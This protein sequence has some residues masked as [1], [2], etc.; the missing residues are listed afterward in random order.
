[1]TAHIFWWLVGAADDVAFLHPIGKG[2]HVAELV[3]DGDDHVGL[4]EVQVAAVHRHP[5]FVQGAAEGFGVGDDRVG[6]SRAAV[7]PL[8]K[9]CGQRG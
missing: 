5:A 6:A 2:A 7:E 4:G 9:C 8:Q 1:M 3:D